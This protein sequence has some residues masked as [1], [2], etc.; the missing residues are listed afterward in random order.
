MNPLRST[1]TRRS[2]KPLYVLLIGLSISLIAVAGLQKL[3]V[4][5]WLP[6]P[7]LNVVHAAKLSPQP[8]QLVPKLTLVDSK[9][10]NKK[11]PITTTE[12]SKASSLVPLSKHEIA[13]LNEMD[14][15]EFL[16]DGMFSFNQ[17]VDQIQTAKGLVATE[18][19]LSHIA[20]L[21][22][23]AAVRAGLDIGE[24]N[25]HLKIQEYATA[26]FDTAIIAGKRDLTFANLQAFTIAAA[27][28]MEKGNS[29]LSLNGTPAAEWK[30]P[31]I[32][33]SEEKFAPDQ[34]ILIDYSLSTTAK[35]IVR[36]Q[37]TEGFL[38]KVTCDCSLRGESKLFSKD[39]YAPEPTVIARAP[40][41][42]KTGA[43]PKSPGSTPASTSNVIEDIPT[44]K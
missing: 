42:T 21:L 44:L 38:I 25:T 39:Y 10:I 27:V 24:R 7:W 20:G 6:L 9:E 36:E 41:A 4:V 33:V 30:A 18:A 35:D 11:I 14:Q 37:G 29:V 26:G 43:A 3:G 16:P 2:F 15:L 5:E 34:L 40:E 32:K 19:E 23:E 8:N 17:W 31:T 28:D 13:W 1:S 22:Y 12:L